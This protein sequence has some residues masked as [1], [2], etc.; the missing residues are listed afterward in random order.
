MLFKEK[1]TLQLK[2]LKQFIVKEKYFFI[3]APLVYFLFF[4]PLW[5]PGNFFWGSDIEVLHFPARQYLYDTIVNEHRFP[6]WT[7]KMLLGFPIYADMENAYLNPLNVFSIIIFG[8]IFSFKLL[9]LIHYLVASFYLKELLKRHGIKIKG[10][11]VANL[12][13]FFSFFFLDHGIHLDII[14]ISMLFPIFLYLMEKYFETPQIKTLLQQATLFAYAVYWGHP[15]ILILLVMGILLYYLTAIATKENLKIALKYFL[16]VGIISVSLALPQLIPSAKIFLQS[17][18]D[19]LGIDPTQ[20]SL[21]PKLFTTT[22][23]PFLYGRWNYY[24]GNQI[25]PTF[26]YTET[27]LY[28]GLTI[29]LLSFTAFL[30]SKK[31]NRLFSFAY[32]SFWLFIVLATLRFVPVLPSIPPFDMF[33]YWTRAVFISSLGLGILAGYLVENLDEIKLSTLKSIGLVIFPFIYLIGIEILYANDL[34]VQKIGRSFEVLQIKYYTTKDM[35]LWFGILTLIPFLLSVRKYLGNKVVS[36]LLCVLVLFD[37]GFYAQDMLFARIGIPIKPTIPQTINYKNKRVVLDA[38]SINV[39]DV[40]GNSVLLLPSWSPY[41]YTQFLSKTYL[42][43][44]ITNKIGYTTK[45]TNAKIIQASDYKKL[46][47]DGFSGVLTDSGMVNITEGNDLDLI[48]NSEV[49]G[50]YIKKE[51]GNIVLE[52]ETSKS[53]G[54]GDKMILETNIKYDSNW[55]VKVN[56]GVVE[57]KPAREIF[58]D[59]EIPE[60]KS[61]IEIKYVPK[62]IYLGMVLGGFIISFCMFILKKIVLVNSLQK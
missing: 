62:D 58:F 3:L 41:G 35:L 47:K 15:H 32:A 56:G 45:G 29:V 59:I 49:S 27:Y 28:M 52:I 31:R 22:I 26:T 19:T 24:Y 2:K 12:A 1:V 51:E 36:L 34:M 42:D 55:V 46:R 5:K 13:F 60:G 39:A 6:L 16:F 20:G 57:I 8:P 50:K 4:F 48:R 40:E 9:H 43:Y 54:N 30:F 33:R 38:E 11:F 53:G 18:R 17:S 14:M 7:E 61:V 37:F 21:T 23:F 44:Y 25:S 10:W